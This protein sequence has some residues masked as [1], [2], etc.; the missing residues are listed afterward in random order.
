MRKWLPVFCLLLMTAASPAQQAAGENSADSVEA[1]LAKYGL[2]GNWAS[3]CSKPAAPGNNHR[4]YRKSEGRLQQVNSLGKDYAENVY[5]ILEATPLTRDR[6][7]IKAV[8][9]G[10]RGDE[11]NTMEWVVDG[12]RMRTYSNVSDKSGPLV[13]D[14]VILSNKRETPWLTRCD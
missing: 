13:T 5:T 12:K 11:G 14:G 10:S 3:D 1:T 9:H 4:R 2:T 6:L 7:R 8:F